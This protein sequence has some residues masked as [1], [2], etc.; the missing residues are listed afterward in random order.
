MAYLHNVQLLQLCSLDQR[1][2]G[3]GA[4]VSQSELSISVQA[5]CVCASIGEAG[6]GVSQP[7]RHL[8]H[9]KMICA[10]YPCLLELLQLVHL[11]ARPCFICNNNIYLFAA[12]NFRSASAILQPCLFAAQLWRHGHQ[13]RPW[14][15]LR[16]RTF[17]A[18]TV[19]VPAPAQQGATVRHS[20]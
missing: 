6:Y 2:A 5:P 20:T 11:P 18:L 13:L 16:H 12:H 9:R 8:Q 19:Q 3:A 10:Q 7:C 4:V 15:L 1:W 17:A 14:H